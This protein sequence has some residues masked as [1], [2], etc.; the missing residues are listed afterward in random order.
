MVALPGFQ[1][2]ARLRYPR[3][4][5]GFTLI[6]L[7]TVITVIGILAVVA[8]PSMMSVI[9]SNRLTTQANEMVAALQ[10]ARSSAI[11]RNTHVQVCVTKDEKTCTPDLD[12]TG[13]LVGVGTGGVIT[14]VIQHGRFHSDLKMARST[15]L[16]S[17]AVDFGPDGRARNSSGQLLTAGFMVCMNTRSPKENARNIW[18]TGGSSFEVERYDAGSPCPADMQDAPLD[19]G[20]GQ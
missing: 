15:S 17:Q 13:W 2:R 10:L 6:E 16:A 9:N 8:A 5:D 19:S 14:E 12:W 3:R 20:T 11:T 18:I 1:S 7:V 4:A